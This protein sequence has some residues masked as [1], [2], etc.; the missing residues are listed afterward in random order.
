MTTLHISDLSTSKEL[1]G[2]AMAAVRGGSDDQAVGTSQANVQSMV[3]AANVGNG[4]SFGGPAD[5]QSDNTFTQTASNTNTASNFDGAGLLARL[6]PRF[7][8]FPF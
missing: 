8:R 7:P 4:S 6:G 2:K 1:D 5:I 3:A